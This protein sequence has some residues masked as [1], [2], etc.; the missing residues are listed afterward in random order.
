M[1]KN[2]KIPISYT[3][4]DDVHSVGSENEMDDQDEAGT[5]FI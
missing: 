4:K 2:I 1:F 5:S 3:D